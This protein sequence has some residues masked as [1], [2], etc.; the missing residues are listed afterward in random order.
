MVLFFTFQLLLPFSYVR[1][2]FPRIQT[3]I[4]D[5]RNMIEN[6]V[7]SDQSSSCIEQG[8]LEACSHYRCQLQSTLQVILYLTLNNKNVQWLSECLTPNLGVEG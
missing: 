3:A 8:L 5:I 1:N 2:N 4:Y 6:L 7:Q